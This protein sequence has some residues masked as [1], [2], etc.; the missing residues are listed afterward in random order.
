MKLYLY[1]GLNFET[2]PMDVTHV[3]VDNSVA[4]IKEWS[5]NQCNLL[6]SVIMGDNVKIIEDHAFYR[7]RVIRFIRL[8]RMLEYIGWRAFAKCLALEALFLPSTV[9][10]IMNAAFWGCQ[11]LRLIILPNGIDL[12]NV[13]YAI[14][15]N[16]PIY[17]IPENAGV[18]YDEDELPFAYESNR[19][20]NEWLFHHMD[21][22]PF[23]TLCYNSYITTSQTNEYLH[24]SGNDSALAI[25]AI[26]RMRPLHMLSMNPHAPAE[27]IAALLDCNM[28]AAFCLDDQQKT[29]LEY[30]RDYNVGGLVGMVN[31]LCNYRNGS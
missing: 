21:E 29:P 19:R 4:V 1:Q 6:V 25:N 9:K 12:S 13:G 28:E 15:Y 31:G 18:A 27:T 23:H 5:F 20:V 8:S 17:Q 2:V 14:I 26:Y 24:A 7:C 3:I 16:T 11:S 30:A 10:S 22:A